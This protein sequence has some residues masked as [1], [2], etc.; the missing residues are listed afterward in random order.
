MKRSK[1]GLVLIIIGVLIVALA[2]IWKWGLGPTLVKLP[3]DIDGTSIYEGV[4]TLSIDPESFSPLPPDMTVKVPLTIVRK[5]ISAPEKSTGSVAVIK[6]TAEAKGPG[7][8]DFLTY[9]KY[10][11]LDRK[12]A[13]N[14]TSDEADLKN[15]KDYSL[16]LGF[17]LD[18]S[19]KMIWDDDVQMSG[20]ARF[21]KTVKMDGY[22]SKD[23]EL[24]VYTA[25][26]EDVTKAPPLGMP[27][28]ISGAEIKGVLNNP[29]LPLADTEMYAIPFLKATEATLMADVKTG[30]IVNLDM[31]ETYSVD[32]TAFGMGNI[33]LA[34]LHY[35]QTPENV[36]TN[37][38][39]AAENYGLLAAV[40]TYIPLGLL[41]IGLIILIIGLVLFL[42]KR[43][44]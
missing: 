15:R 29:T 28:K 44:A 30:Q 8:K 42:R 24:N 19:N 22:D 26:G 33:T 12:T 40:E 18:E 16:T 20:E 10:Y 36:K 37:I 5:D 23:I 41:I 32:A 34:E 1:A 7:G 9:T 27:D 11:A 31:K 3:D 13:K 2:P 17:G 21:V 43:E 35:V 25:S 6:E 14:V 38:D 4:L 39:S